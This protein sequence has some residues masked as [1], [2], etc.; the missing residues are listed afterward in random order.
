MNN[1]KRQVF[2]TNLTKFIFGKSSLYQIWIKGKVKGRFFTKRT[3]RKQNYKKDNGE[4]MRHQHLEIFSNLLIEWTKIF[5][6][7]SN[8]FQTKFLVL[9]TTY[10]CCAVVIT[11]TIRYTAPFDH[12]KTMIVLLVIILLHAQAILMWKHFFLSFS[13]LHTER[14]FSHQKS[15]QFIQFYSLLHIDG[16][17]RNIFNRKLKY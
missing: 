12:L 7:R 16:K 13:F 11:P 8:I 2:V 15:H 17:W 10:S 14:S 6:E 5:V 1:S 9:Q 3:Q 4:E